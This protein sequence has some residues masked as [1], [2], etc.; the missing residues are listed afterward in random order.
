VLQLADFCTT[1][2]GRSPAAAQI[3]EAPGNPADPDARL[4]RPYLLFES[5]YP[6]FP[7]QSSWGDNKAFVFERT[8]GLV[9]DP[10]KDYPI[11]C[12]QIHKEIGKPVSDG[13][14]L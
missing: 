3:S 4:R 5:I 12:N 2:T 10:V 8:S 9:T 7:C 14:Y 6:A 13:I 11:S 1:I